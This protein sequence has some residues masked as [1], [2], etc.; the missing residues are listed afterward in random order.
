[1]SIQTVLFR[2]RNRMPLVDFA[3]E[4]SEPI[5]ESLPSRSNVVAPKLRK[6]FPEIW[7]WKCTD[8]RFVM[9]SRILHEL[10]LN[11]RW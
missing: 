2:R 6:F 5:T 11:V 8:A 1:M 7:I 9:V 10:S 3:E 4:D